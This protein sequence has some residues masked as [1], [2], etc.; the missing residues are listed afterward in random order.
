MCTLHK[1]GGVSVC[2]P[3]TH[4][5]AIGPFV[6]CLRKGGG[7]SSEAFAIFGALRNLLCLGLKFGHFFVGG[8]FWHRHQ[9]HGQVQIDRRRRRGFA[10]LLVEDVLLD[11]GIGNARTVFN[12]SFAQTAD[13]ELVAKLFAKGAGTQSFGCHAFDE[14]I[15]GNLILARN[16]LLGLLD[17]GIIH[18]DTVVTGLLQLSLFIDQLVQGLLSQGFGIGFGCTGGQLTLYPKFEQ[19]NVIV[20]DGL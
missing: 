3:E 18:T 11:L 14:L 2:R 17:V 4:F 20:G 12:V 16:A 19:L 1:Q 13:H 6:G 9:N 15:S 8:V 10:A 7:Q 5:T